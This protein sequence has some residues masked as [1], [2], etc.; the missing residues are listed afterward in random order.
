MRRL[1]G[2]TERVQKV[3]FHPGGDLLASAGEDQCVRLW[4]WRRGETV[5]VLRGHSLAVTSVAFSSHGKLLASA[6]DD[7]SIHLWD[8]DGILESGE[9][10]RPITPA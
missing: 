1:R 7:G 9:P 8:L 2:H 10:S 5:H 3:A 4:D 6:G